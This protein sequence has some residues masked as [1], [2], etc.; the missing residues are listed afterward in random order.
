MSDCLT[1]YFLWISH[2]QGLCICYTAPAFPYPL[3]RLDRVIPDLRQPSVAKVEAYQMANKTYEKTTKSIDKHVG[4]VRSTKWSPEE[5]ELLVRYVS[6]YGEHNW[7]GASKQLNERFYNSFTVREGKH[8][9]E[10]WFNHLNP[11][12]K[13]KV[14]IE[15]GWTEAEDALL[16]R[17]HLE[18]R[19][20]WSEISRKLIGRNDNSVKNR[21]YSLVKKA[22]L[23]Q[24]MS[25]LTNEEVRDRLINSLG[26]S[27]QL[28]E[29]AS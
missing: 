14:Y 12:L 8:A 20:C 2:L 23:Q 3:M 6:K 24:G 19:N 25:S 29:D 13:S 16:L 18:H 22:R 10:R 15:G 1:D 26:S 17:L 4:S 28:T 21:F 27:G 5:D 9:R 7:A 11:D